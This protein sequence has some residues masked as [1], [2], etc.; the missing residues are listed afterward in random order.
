M[1]KFLWKIICSI[2]LIAIGYVLC[3]FNLIPSI[4]EGIKGIF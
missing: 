4:I 3:H 1:F 2:F